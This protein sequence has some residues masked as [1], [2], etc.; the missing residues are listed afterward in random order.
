[1]ELRRA[2]E[3]IK[4]VPV[5]GPWAYQA[6]LKARY[7]EGRVLEI[8]AGPLRGMRWVRFMRTFWHGYVTG[9]YESELV[10]AILREAHSGGTFYDVGANAGLMS[11]AGAKA[12]GPRGLVVAF[13]P[14]PETVRQLR[15]QLDANGIANA[16]VVEAAASD[17]E[18]RAEFQD[19]G[20]SDVLSLAS[21]AD[22]SFRTLSV[23][24][25]T[26][27]KVALETR[28]PDLV[29]IDVEGADMLVLRGAREMLE[30]HHPVVIMELHTQDIAPE[31]ETFMNDLG[32][33]H[34]EL[35][36]QAIQGPIRSHHVISKYQGAG[37]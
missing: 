14:H 5:V 23:R 30:R 18:G 27:T 34:Y 31:Y 16:E 12:V 9:E 25:T 28:A 7:A 13:E 2:R 6:Y 4:S 21:V 36:G 17:R 24:T 1:M 10:S 33:A 19:E 37:P 15:S 35:N 32:Y 22:R 3:L 8:Q 20:S 26:L 11:L 29:K